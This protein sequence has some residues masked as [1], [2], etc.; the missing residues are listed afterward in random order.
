MANESYV[1]RD[2]TISHIISECSKLELKEYKIRHYWVEK[3]I[4]LELC[5]KFKFDHTNEWFRIRP[6]E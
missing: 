3:E 4:H 5:K 1:V 2:K 6:G